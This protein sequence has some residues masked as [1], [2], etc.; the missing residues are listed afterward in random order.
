MFTIETIH[1][2]GVV[3]DQNDE[4]QDR[5]LLSKPEAQSE[6]EELD[7]IERFRKNDAEA[8]GHREPDSEAHGDQAKISAPVAYPGFLICHMVIPA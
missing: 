6:A 1:S 4:A 5:A 8:E 3:E 7:L 2:P